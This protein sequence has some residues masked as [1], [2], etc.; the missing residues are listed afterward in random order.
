M[1][2]F[3]C[4]NCQKKLQAKPALAG[5][6]A[7]C[8]QCGKPFQVP[9][10]EESPESMPLDD[11][12]AGDTAIA[13]TEEHLASYPV[14][15]RLNREYH[16]LICDR[17]RM[18]AMWEN[19][20][21]GWMIRAGAGFLPAKRNRDKLPTSGNFQLTEL[22]FSHTPEGKRLSGI[23][24][25]QLSQR[26]ALTALDQADDAILEKVTGAG[27]L[28]RDQKNAVRQ[29][30]RD[31]FMRP[32]WQDSVAILEYLGNTDYHSPGVAAE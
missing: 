3:A 30:L 2:S 26:W 10:A 24:S 15:N 19:N 14:P 1:I 29:S 23:T 4:P 13:V 17:A 12:P 7:K 27:C 5:R 22:K 9:Q 20:G 8:P 28:N 11:T 32:V 25:Y 16:Y 6:T 18:V 31:H 21:A